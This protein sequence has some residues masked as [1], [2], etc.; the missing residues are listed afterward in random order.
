MRILSQNF[1]LYGRRGLRVL[2][3]GGVATVCG[4]CAIF[5]KNGSAGFTAITFTF[6]VA[7]TINTTAP[8]IYDVAITASP[9]PNPLNQYAPLPVINSSN[10][11]GRVAGSPT[12]F[13][14]FNSANPNSPNPFALYRF[15]L[16]SEVPNPNDPTNP[17]NLAV[18]APS[19][20]GQI[21]NFTT[22][23]TGGDPS[24]L[25]FTVYTNMLADTDAEAKALQSLQVNILTMTRLGNQGGGTRVIDALGD[26]R[27]VSGL[28][29]F[30]V[31]NLNQTIPYTNLNN[32]EPT[33]D[34]Y[35]GTEPDVDINNF[36]ITVT[37]P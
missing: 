23:Q 37:P 2:A 32:F 6:S 26:S 17:I 33:G 24:T 19:T 35:G 25:S 9:L 7:G 14:E 20:R 28:N 4:S 15:A 1:V 11:N 8:F 27:S 12:H 21:F 34:T 31:V 13:I 36:T 22:P 29:Q 3:L 5:P 16:S 10:P 30:L 18:F